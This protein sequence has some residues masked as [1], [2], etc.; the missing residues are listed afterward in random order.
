M[1]VDEPLIVLAASRREGGIA[2]GNDSGL[3]VAVAI[4]P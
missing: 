4:P 1:N 3:S 2:V